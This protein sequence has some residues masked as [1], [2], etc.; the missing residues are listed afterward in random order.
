MSYSF[1]VKKVG[2]ELVVENGGHA[3]EH[4]P[5]GASF[6]VQGHIPAAGTSQYGSIGVTLTVPLPG[7]DYGQLLAAASG[8][9]NAAPVV[10]EPAA[11]ETS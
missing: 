11:E 7:V 3:A 9:C 4:L 8:G 5:D 1:N 6:T 2:G 10:A